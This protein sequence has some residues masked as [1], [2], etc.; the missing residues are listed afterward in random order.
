MEA[1]LHQVASR[2]QIAQLGRQVAH[3]DTVASGILDHLYAEHVVERSSHEVF[4]GPGVADGFI[5]FPQVVLDLLRLDGVL[6]EDAAR[7]LLTLSSLIHH[8][9]DV[10]L[11][12]GG[13]GEVTEVKLQLLLVAFLLQSGALD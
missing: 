8:A 11:R 13:F 1:D 3:D 4:N 2:Q 6:R 12:R 7:R 9:G 10:G 5:H